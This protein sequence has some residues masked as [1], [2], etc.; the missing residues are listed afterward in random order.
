M[1][2]RWEDNFKT[3]TME[4]LFS[5]CSVLEVEEKFVKV[6]AAIKDNMEGGDDELRNDW[7]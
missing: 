5:T 6:E 4:Q 2:T 3:F 7:D 1:T